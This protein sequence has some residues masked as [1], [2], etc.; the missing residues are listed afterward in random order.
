M[1]TSAVNFNSSILVVNDKTIFFPRADTM[2]LLSYDKKNK[3]IVFTSSHWSSYYSGR[4]DTITYE[5]K[6]DII[7]YSNR[8][9]GGGHVGR[10]LMQTP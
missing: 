9:H 8:S 4:E 6:N 7:Y 5:Y 10:I 3:R 2:K 1:D